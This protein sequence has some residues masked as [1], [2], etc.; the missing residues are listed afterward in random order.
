MPYAIIKEKKNNKMCYKVINTNSKR[1]FSKCTTN[2][3]SM[4]QLRLLNAIIY[5][6]DFVPN[7]SKKNKRTTRKIKSN[8]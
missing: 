8:K 2:K 5:S 4:K 7:N 6:K 1:V 3:R